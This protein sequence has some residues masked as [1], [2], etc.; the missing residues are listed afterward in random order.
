MSTWFGERKPILLNKDGWRAGLYATAALFLAPLYFTPLILMIAGV[1]GVAVFL[2]GLA[3]IPAATFAARWAIHL[4]RG[5]LRIAGEEIPPPRHNPGW[6]GLVDGRAWRTLGHSA[7]LAFWSLGAGGLVAGLLLIAFLLV[8]LPWIAT[9]IP[10]DYANINGFPISFGASAFGIP[11]GLAI[12]TG[13]LHLARW[14]VRSEALVGRWFQGEG[15]RLR[16][17]R[18]IETLESTRTAMIDA[19]AAERARIERNL[20]DGAQ[21]RLLAVA[22][23]VSRAKRIGDTDMEKTRRLLDTAQ[24]E[25][26]AAVQELRE[27]ARGAHPPIL[28]E[29]GLV[30]AVVS[31]A[32]RHPAPVELDIELD[33]RPSP[34]IEALG[35]YVVSE[36][37]ANAAKHAGAASVTIT[38][39]RA[40]DDLEVRIVDDGMGGAQLSPGGGL[41]GLAD[42]VHA[43]DG[44]FALQSP[45]GG[46]TEMKATIPWEA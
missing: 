46:P 22:L 19:A 34:R 18:R 30:A 44:T 29:R 16:L 7:A 41:A 8:N 13:A 17:Q 37:L 35:Y 20:H 1:V 32:G 15:G 27:I 24:S 31:A 2:I 39:S 45:L 33:E 36:A 3:L 42:R 4:E 28:T 11:A 9:M 21:Q 43:V 40:A 38:L 25:A 23:A 12:A 5:A 26:Q 10:I 6:R 14:S